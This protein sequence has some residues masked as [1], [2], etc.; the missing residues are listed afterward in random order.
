MANSCLRKSTFFMLIILLLSFSLNVSAQGNVI[1]G[2]VIAEDDGS[3]LIGVNITN[4]K[5]NKKTV[6]NASGKFTITAEK[7]ETLVFSYTSYSTKQVVVG[8]VKVINITLAAAEKQLDDVVVTAYGI[9]R[10]K[11]SLGYSTQSVTGEDIS[12]TKKR[13]FY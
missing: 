5:T 1:T 10:E 8:D 11:K 4:K 3:P 12:Q 9:K 6:T 7:G 2:T 13:Q